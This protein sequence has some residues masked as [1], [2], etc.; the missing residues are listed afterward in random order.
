MSD[1]QIKR[2]VPEEQWNQAKEYVKGKGRMVD[3]INGYITSIHIRLFQIQRE[4]EEKDKKITAQRVRD[5]YYGNDDTRK[6]LLQLF[7]EPANAGN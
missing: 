2:S 5:I 4:L 6:N 1:I 3:E 7:E